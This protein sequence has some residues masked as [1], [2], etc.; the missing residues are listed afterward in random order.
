MNEP[1]IFEV[2][3]RDLFDLTVKQS[4][5][6]GENEKRIAGLER[7]LFWTR[8]LAFYLIFAIVALVVA[9]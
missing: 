2:P 7:A 1:G 6:L 8:G 5:V 4:R 9:S 3:V